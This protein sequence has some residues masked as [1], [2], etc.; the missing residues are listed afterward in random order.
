MIKTFANNEGAPEHLAENLTK[1]VTGFGDLQYLLDNEKVCSVFI[2]GTNSVHIEIGGKVLNTEIKLS[3]N[4]LNFILNYIGTGNGNIYTKTVD[5]YT[6]TVINGDICK[7]PNITIKKNKKLILQDL[8][9]NQM[10]TLEIFNILSSIITQ[11]KNFIISGDINSGKSTLLEI[12]LQNCLMDKRGYLFEFAPKINANSDFWIKFKLDNRSKD[13]ND[14]LATVLKTS[15]EFIISDFNNAIKYFTGCTMRAGS[16][17]EA[18]N[19][20][21]ALY[22]DLPEKYAKQ[23]ALTDFDYIIQLNKMNDG[24]SKLTSIVELKPAKTMAQSITTIAEYSYGKYFT[25]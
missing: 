8:I 25:I 9:D 22:S 20:L 7:T 16:V 23:K 3:Q 13:F 14:V 12:L 18:F 6:V 24:T 4:S 15:P 21:V 1:S 2:N 10:L 19:N 11:K 17:T 5:N